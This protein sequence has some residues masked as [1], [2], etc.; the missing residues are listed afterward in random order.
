MANNI[1]QEPYLLEE[2]VLKAIFKRN[3]ALIEAMDIINKDMFTIKDYSY[4]YQ[5]MIEV[6]KKEDTIN[7]ENIKLW[8]EDNN[9]YITDIGIIDKLYNE[10]YTSINI[11]TTCNIIKE[12][13]R[14]RSILV[15][16]SE[17]L[18]SCKEATLTSDE[19]LEKVND[20]AMNANER[21]STNTENNTDID[22]QGYMADILTK[23]DKPDSDEKY[24]K[25]GWSSIDN[26][27]GGLKRG[28]LINFTGDSGTGK[29]YWSNQTA[30][31]ICTLQP[32]MYVDI[33]SL[34]MNK[35]ENTERLVSIESGYNSKALEDPHSFF[36]RFNEETGETYNLYDLNGKDDKEVQEYL[37]RVKYAT[38]AISKMNIKIDDT[39]DLR[40]GDIEARAKMNH[41]K[42]G[43]TDVIII[44]HT[45][46]LHDGDP[47]KAVGEITQI[48]T[49]LK[50]LAKKLN[51]VIIALHQFNNDIKEGDRRPSVFNLRGS[52]TI[53]HN[54]DVIMLLYRPA[55]YSDLIRRQPDLK[56]VCDIS[57]EKVR[58]FA[59]VD[60]QPMMFFKNI[61]GFEEGSIDDDIQQIILDDEQIDNIST[62]L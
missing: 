12:L 39:P 43:R 18:D 25:T 46:L 22:T 52:G 3:N 19:I 13:Y 38:D 48:Y 31:K 56:D 15:E 8:L 27:F 58:G 7:N 6:Y 11:E 17:F 40:I 62:V 60:P 9:I 28:W 33:Y 16:V 10:S 41:L 36:N 45:D 34:E 47:A 42:R 35:E 23:L 49:R 20:I 14:R 1:T 59:K 57:F 30:V 37:T 4:I 2:K 29:S 61:C 53:R 26:A 5:A 55:V 50:K 21:F 51:C 32:E 54:C 44:D 24:I